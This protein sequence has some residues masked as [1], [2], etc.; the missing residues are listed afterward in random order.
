[1]ITLS[2]NL[3]DWEKIIIILKR[4][5]KYLYKEIQSLIKKS[6]PI[7]KKLKN[8][9]KSKIKWHLTLNLFQVFRIVCCF[10]DK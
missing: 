4:Y 1:M 2:Y 9:K 5:L 8:K 10:E 6:T 7:F 3:A